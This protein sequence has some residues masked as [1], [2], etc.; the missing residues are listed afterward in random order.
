MRVTAHGR[1]PEKSAIRDKCVTA[2]KTSKIMPST[3]ERRRAQRSVNTAIRNG[4]AGTPGKAELDKKAANE[5]MRGRAYKK[6]KAAKEKDRVAQ[7]KDSVAA[8][9]AA[10]AAR[11]AEKDLAEAAAAAQEAE[12]DRAVEAATR[13][14]CGE[15]ARKRAFR[16]LTPH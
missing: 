14:S 9:C 8:W 7:E 4:A 12:K 16:P 10:E 6:K 5:V 1:G 2:R 11:K 3:P 15:A 13:R